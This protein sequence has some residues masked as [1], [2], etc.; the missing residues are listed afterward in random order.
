MGRFLL[1]TVQHKQGA[2]QVLQQAVHDNTAAV[3]NCGH[4]NA[5]RQ[6]QGCIVHS[7]VLLAGRSRQTQSPHTTKVSSSIAR[8]QN[9]Q[10]T[11]SHT[12]GHL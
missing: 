2:Q 7:T 3:R 4:S 1:V 6:T 9:S 10:H 12:H 8:S 11:G 5:T